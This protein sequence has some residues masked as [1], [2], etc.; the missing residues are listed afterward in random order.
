MAVAVVTVVA[1]T[2][3]SSSSKASTP[4]T[5]VNP[6]RAAVAPTSGEKSVRELAHT[7]LSLV[8]DGLPGLGPV[9]FPP[10]CVEDP[11]RKRHIG[12]LG[13]A[14][15]AMLAAERGRRLC[16][17]VRPAE[18]TAQQGE[19]EEA[20]RWGVEVEVLKGTIRKKTAVSGF[21]LSE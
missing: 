13:K 16:A 1:A 19:A 7:A 14:V 12:A 8:A 11:R 4:N 18:G 10:R 9:A 17:G 20:K 5:Y 15:E 3:S 21:S 2:G 6:S